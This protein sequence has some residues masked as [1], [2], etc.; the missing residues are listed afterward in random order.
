[1]SGRENTSAD[2]KQTVRLN[3]QEVYTGVTTGKVRLAEV[4]TMQRRKG[5]RSKLKPEMSRKSSKR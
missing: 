5:E 3:K 4:S 1:M 2:V